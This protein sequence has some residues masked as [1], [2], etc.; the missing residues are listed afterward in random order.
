MLIER[1]CGRIGPM[2]ESPTDVRVVKLRNN[3]SNQVRG[4]SAL[5]PALKEFG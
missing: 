2:S 3:S 4:W 1:A 5:E